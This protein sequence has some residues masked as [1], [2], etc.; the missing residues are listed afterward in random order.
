MT[1][2][3]DT[4][5]ADID[6]TLADLRRLRRSLTAVRDTARD[7]E[8]RG[9]HA[10]VCRIIEGRIGRL[11]SRRQVTDAGA[12]GRLPARDA[13]ADQVTARLP[14]PGVGYET[15]MPNR[16]PT[17]IG[18]VARGLVAGASATAVM[19]AAQNIY[20]EATG[21]QG[22]STPGEAGRGVLEGVFNRRVSPQQVS[23]PLTT[24]VHW[25]YGTGLGVPYA[26]VAG[27]LRGPSA[28]AGALAL[29]V[30]VWASSRAGMAAMQL[31][32]PPWQD[33][34]S[35][36]AMDL[37]FHLLYGVTGAAVFRALH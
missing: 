15:A 5:I 16:T 35:M 7:T 22:S 36:L 25:V 34:P 24:G 13:A 9:E 12:L 18:A 19:T 32:P 28:L 17:P 30:G 1:E 33:P 21:S 27:S 2:L 11:I 23:G 6:R 20:Y 3:L 29:G 31:A 37:G 8:R 14:C 10:V 26:L 4:H